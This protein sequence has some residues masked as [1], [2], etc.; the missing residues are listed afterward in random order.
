[1]GEL[2]GADVAQLRALATAVRDNTQTLEAARAQVDALMDGLDWFGPGG[3]QFRAE[4]SERH[5]ANLSAAIDTL[6]QA[7]DALDR[8]ADSQEQ[9]SEDAGIAGGSSTGPAGGPTVAT[10]AGPAGGPPAQVTTTPL[11][12]DEYTDLSDAERQEWLKTASD[13]QIA[14]LLAAMEEQGLYP[15]PDAR[16][17]A[18]THWTRQAAQDA[19]IDYRAW[20]PTLGAQAN[21]DNIEAVYEYYAQLYLENPDLQW[22]GMAAMIGPS[23]AA[24]FLDLALFRDIAQGFEVGGEVLQH[25]PNGLPAGAL[26]EQVA[27]M[28]DE[29]LRY[30]ETSFLAMQQEIFRDQA[31]MHA[32]YEHG[33]MAE[34]DKMYESGAID[35]RAYDAWADIASGDPERVTEGNTEML[36]REQQDIIAD[37]YDAMR[38]HPVTGEAM[39]YMMT[40]VGEASIP[41]AGTFADYSPL[42]VTVETPGP[43]GVDIPFT[44]V[45]I[46]NPLQGSVT[47]TTPLPDGNIADTG[48]R[49]DYITADTLPAYQEL[50]ANDP[51]QVRDILETD[52]SDRI[53]EY[54]L[55]NPDRL[56]RIADDLATNWDVDVN[57]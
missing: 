45:S 33:G 52:V 1:M 15:G 20:D 55:T 7:G 10:A 57:Q 4:W 37:D 38:S 9:T 3:D 42:S 21:R 46:D 50:L 39:T 26:I 13:E 44:G 48:Q 28:T 49:W 32:A 53:A 29:E 17:V 22:A 43:Q 27:A 30:Y 18:T 41:G 51:G 36:R 2:W 31:S 35:E 25:L 12:P 56:G 16:L 47:V 14:D 8:N 19:G 5:R 23:F 11:T 54:R 40:V 6:V 34:I 24:G